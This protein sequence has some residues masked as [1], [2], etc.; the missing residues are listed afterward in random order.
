MINSFKLTLTKAYL[1]PHY[2][3]S[4]EMK[5][6]CENTSRLRSGEIEQGK[7]F[8][9]NKSKNLNWWLHRLSTC[10][11]SPLRIACS[12]LLFLEYTEL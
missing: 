1:K 9:F 7:Y 8:F 6:T 3:L 5:P 4:L 2:F 10:G 12:N 11:E